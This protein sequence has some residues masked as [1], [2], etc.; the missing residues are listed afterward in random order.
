MKKLISILI[1]FTILCSCSE[2]ETQVNSDTIS[3]KTDSQNITVSGI[4][5][6]TLPVTDSIKKTRT[7]SVRTHIFKSGETLWELGRKY[8]G[9]RHYSSLTAHYNR[10]ENVNKIEPGTL[11]KV[12]PF[13]DM[14]LYTDFGLVPIM[15]E[16]V[17]KIIT[18]RELFMKHQQLLSDIREDKKRDERLDLPANTVADLQKANKLTQDIIESLKKPKGVNKSIPKSMINQLKNVSKNLNQ[19]SKG[20][21]DGPYKYDLDMFHQNLIHAIKGGIS[22]AKKVNE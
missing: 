6:D 18:I 17:E 11:I 3:E 19:L 10:I 22:W 15:Q 4:M 12:P 2:N 8:Y 16:E 9:N 21:H 1:L 7:D 20:I 13:N 14:L 5:L